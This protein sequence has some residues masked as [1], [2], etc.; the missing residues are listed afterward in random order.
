MQLGFWAENVTPADCMPLIGQAVTSLHES[1]VIRLT[2]SQESNP[3]MMA[4]RCPPLLS[5]CDH[6]H[7]EVE[8]SYNGKWSKPS[9]V[10]C[11]WAEWVLVEKKSALPLTRNIWL[12][13]THLSRMI[14]LEQKCHPMDGYVHLLYTV[15]GLYINDIVWKTY[16]I[17]RLSIASAFLLRFSQKG[18][19]FVLLYHN[20]K[21]PC[22]LTTDTSHIATWR[23]VRLAGHY[24]FDHCLKNRLKPHSGID[25]PL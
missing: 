8:L 1:W 4:P 18:E 22:L 5:C 14:A 6:S 19:T 9:P 7:I 23:N 16:R 17:P 12:Q 21:K 3:P 24:C 20:W 10:E 13:N 25:F 15:Y 11:S 2:A